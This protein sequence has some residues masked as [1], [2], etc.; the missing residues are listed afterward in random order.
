MQLLHARV[1]VQTLTEHR[2][3][4][5]CRRFITATTKYFSDPVFSEYCGASP[6]VRRLPTTGLLGIHV[7]ARADRKVTLQA[8][9]FPTKSAPRETGWP[10]CKRP[11]PWRSVRDN[12]A[13]QKRMRDMED[14]PTVVIEKL[15]AK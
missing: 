1:A 12:A 14:T 10:V 11:S 8:S 6:E 13:A 3:N 2:L 15:V 5:E 7:P 4:R 9:L